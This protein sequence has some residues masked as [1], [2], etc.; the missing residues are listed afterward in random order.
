MLSWILFILFDIAVLLGIGLFIAT[1]LLSGRDLP[2]PDWTAQE[3]GRFLSRGIGGGRAEVGAITIRMTSNALPEVVFRDVTVTAP[4]GAELVTVPSL[5]VALDK[6]ALWQGEVQPRALRVDGATLE[7]R[8]KAD[9][10]FDLGFGDGGALSAFASLDEAVAAVQ[11]VFELPGLAPVERLEVRSLRVFY[12]DAR[13]EKAWRISDG[14][15]LL[16]HT[17]DA[18]SLSATLELPEPG[19]ANETPASVALRLS[20]GKAGAEAEVSALVENVAAA[21]I[22]AHSPALSWLEPLQARVS[23]AVILGTTED[24][25]MGPLNGTLEIGTGLFQPETGARAIPFDG[26]RAY[27]GYSPEHNRITFQELDIRAPDGTVSATGHAYLE[28]IETGWPTALIGQF[29]VSDMRLAPPGFLPEPA[30]F[31]EGAID[32]KLTADPFTARIGQMSLRTA[33]PEGE[34]GHTRL[35]GSGQISADADGWH[36]SLDLGFDEVAAGPLMALWPLGLVPQTRRW[37]GRRMLAGMLRNA[38]AGLRFEP[39]QVPD[40]AMSFEFDDATLQPMDSL[41]PIT[42]ATGFAA[43]GRYRFAVTLE[44][45]QVTPPEGG[46]IDLAGSTFRVRD[47]RQKPSTGEILLHSTSQA[48]AALSLLDQE[49]FR[50]LSNAGQP[51]AL[52]EGEARAD[53]RIAF[54]MKGGLTPED[55]AFRISARAPA[56]SSRVIVPERL[57]EMRDVTLLA[58]PEAMEMTGSGTLDGVPVQGRFDLPFRKDGAAPAVEGRVEIGERFVQTFGIGLP[59]GSVSGAGW[60]G[61]SLVLPRGDTMR[62]RLSSDLVGVGLS[63]PPLGWSKASAAAGTLELAGRLGAR[64]SIEDLELQA[65]GLTASGS[66]TTTAEGGL[67]RARFSRVSVGGW[68]DAP[69]TLTGRGPGR[70]PAIAVEGGRIDIRKTSIGG[71]A[72]SGSTSGPPVTLALDRLTIS[73]SIDLTGFRGTLTKAKGYSGNFTGAV[74]GKAR[75]A[76]TVVPGRNAGTAVRIKSDNAG[77]VFKA[78][79]LFKQAS[80]G[81]MDLVLQPR[82]TAGEY[83][84]QLRVEDIRVRSASGL[85]ALVNA[86]SVVGLI[87]EL[88]GGGILFSDVEA[89]FRLTPSFVHVTRSSGVG[90]SL[91]ISMEGVYD[92]VSDRL[93]MQ[94][95]FSPVYMVNSIGRIFTRKGE[96]LI[97][98]TYRM[99]GSSDDPRVDV[100]PLSALTPGMFREI[101]RAPPPVPNSGG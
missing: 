47:M 56:L 33:D 53:G 94:G 7:L 83:D 90:P 89:V 62:Y 28:G 36:V 32:V 95:V 51:V 20:L 27:F 78:A 68:L 22:A 54:P 77:A 5:Q 48:T 24:G 12:E 13:A 10:T 3:A 70:D 40:V 49:P 34:L 26:A 29:Q 58:T 76:G 98:F 18:L 50:F 71:G 73:D 52:A 100:N 45:G 101:F 19:T 42:G 85:T 41:P 75:V 1:S 63:L 66:L 81:T 91:G 61:F 2:A 35:R 15:L 59:E 39:G 97:G 67:E 6:R 14:T 9:G 17:S 60:G 99:R 8:R 74:N 84:G 38:H 93:N 4:N 31:D 57:L 86:I 11:E 92:M 25:R 23:G 21:D 88:N 64:P 55:V 96:G 37:I 44:Q 69:V 82:K 79:G 80:G 46:P 43:I 65:A 72:N 30:L 16:T 87:D